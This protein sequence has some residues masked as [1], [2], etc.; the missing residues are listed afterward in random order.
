ML[1]DLWKLGTM[2]NA[3]GSLFLVHH[4]LE[5]NLFLIAN[6]TLFWV[7]LMHVHCV[8]GGKVYPVAEE[9]FSIWV[10]CIRGWIGRGHSTFSIPTGWRHLGARRKCL[11]VQFVA[12]WDFW[13]LPACLLDPGRQLC[14]AEHVVG[15]ILVHG[16][17]MCLSV[18][19]P[20]CLLDMFVVLRKATRSAGKIFFESCLVNALEHPSFL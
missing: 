8:R 12:A 19:H 13:L 5:K 4:P 6:L 15:G 2:S 9:L 16:S 1:L 14:I 17:Q 3:L 10:S 7:K 20:H 11:L 18:L